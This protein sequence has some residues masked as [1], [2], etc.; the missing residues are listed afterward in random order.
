MNT[1]DD[2]FEKENGEHHRS[3]G[4]LEAIFSKHEC[5]GYQPEGQEKPPFC[6]QIHGTCKRPSEEDSGQLWGKWIQELIKETTNTAA[7]P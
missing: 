4:E 7:K 2:Y 1:G 3:S 5:G 6:S